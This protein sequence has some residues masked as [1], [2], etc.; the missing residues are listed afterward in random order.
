[1]LAPHPNTGGLLPIL[2]QLGPAA[3]SGMVMPRHHSLDLQGDLICTEFNTRRVSRH[4]LTRSGSSYAAETSTFLESDQTDFHP[5]DVIEDADGSLLVADTGSWYMIC[6]PTSKIAKPD[7]LG[8]IY[9]IEKKG[10]NPHEDPRGLKLDWNQPQVSWLSDE[11]P[12]VVK[13]AIDVLAKE[14]NIDALRMASA[15]IPAVW[16]LH[17]IQSQ[18]VRARGSRIPEC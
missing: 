13:R 8:A 14:S 4:R 18:R 1:M 11:R 6:C 16:S 2:T 9:R 15:R 3:P 10:A 12:S 7:I 17:R 5:T